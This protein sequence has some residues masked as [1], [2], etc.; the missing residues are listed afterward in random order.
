VV[1]GSTS[2]SGLDIARAL[3][4]AGAAVVPNGLDKIDD[5]GEILA[6]IAPEFSVRAIYSPADMAR[7]LCRSAVSLSGGHQHALPLRF[8]RVHEEPGAYA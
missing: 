2:G 8:R 1:T 4:E 7:L 5:V 3:A 6:E